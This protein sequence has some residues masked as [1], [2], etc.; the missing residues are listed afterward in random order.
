MIRLYACKENISFVTSM[1]EFHVA[2]RI[3][4][5]CNFDGSLFASSG[6]IIL[7]NFKNVRLFAK[8]INDMIEKEE[9][10]PV[11]A[12]KKMIK[13]GQL[14]AL[15]LIDEIFHYV[16]AL[17]RRD[18]KADVFDELLI[19]L[20]AAHT[21][22]AVD[23]LLL[24]FTAEFPPTPVYRGE[25]DA[26]AWLDGDALD[27]VTGRT[28]SNRAA[29]LEEMILLRL[30]NEN[31]AFK[32]FFLLFNDK[33]LLRN[34]LY[35]PVWS[36]IKS[37]FAGQ[38]V[39]GPNN[40]DLITMLKEPV[41][42]SPD[43]LKGQL[44]YIRTYWKDLL[45]EW[46]LRLL[47]GMDMIS[48][49]EKAAWAP[50][51]AGG[52]SP[53]M[54]PYNYDSL[55]QEYERFSPDREWM[56]KVVLMA[57]T[58]LVWLDQL[59]KKYEREITRLDQ[60]PD[61][62]LDILA[63]RGFTGLWL[64]GLWERS[65]ASKRIKQICGN[66]EAA[67]S[68]YSLYDYDIAQG[69]GGWGALDNLRRRLWQRGIRLASDMVPN[70]T[71]MDSKWINERP[72]LFVQ[73]RD[74]PFPGYTFNGE[75]LSL[76]D[77]VGV[78]LED[79][80]YSKSDCAVVFKRVDHHT[81]DVRYI[82]HGNDGTGMPWNDTAQ[83][84]FLNPEAREAVMQ[85]ILHVAR[86][87]PIIRFD[88]AMVLAKKHIR[89]LWYPEPGH[90]GDIASRAEYALSRD[91]F[92]TRIPNEFW[93]EVV[94]RVAAEV[95]DTLL[96][97]EAFW[98][99]EGYFVRTLGM[100]RVYNSAFMNMLKREDNSKY[101]STIKNTIEFDPQ[102][103]KRFVNFM[104]NP[105]E[106][107]AVAQFGKGDKYF[108]VC[109]L[110]VTMPGLPMFGHGQIE[111]F[112]EKYGM[113]FTKA[114]W[115]E[116]PDGDLIARHERDIFPL[117][118]KRYLFA[119]IENFLFYDVWD[120]GHVNENV[121]AYSNRS[122]TERAVVFY[123][124]V[125][126]QASGWIKQSC[127]YAVKTGSGEHDIRMETHSIG[128]ALGL[129]PDAGNFCIF[130]EQR[131]GLWFI[132]SAADICNNGLYLHLNGFESQV[133]M[134]ISQVT[135][136]ETGKYR[137]LCETLN[138]RGVSDIDTALREIFLKE[139]YQSFTALVT[140]EFLEA[141]RLLCMPAVQLKTQKLTAP[142]VAEVLAAVEPAARVWFETVDT[143][144]EGNYGASVVV[145]RT[146]CGKKIPA[147]KI[148]KLLE[149]RLTGLFKAAAA[150][151]KKAADSFAVTM[152]EGMASRPACAQML[153]G[154]TVLYSIKDVLGDKATAVDTA[155]LIARW[156]L[157]R[158]LQDML[159]NE[160][161]PVTDTY[162]PLRSIL[163]ALPYSDVIKA[164]KTPSEATVSSAAVKAA[165]GTIAQSV[166]YNPAAAVTAGVNEFNNVLWFNE[167]R[168]TDTLWFAVV[169]PAVMNA[170]VSRY[171][172]LETLLALFTAAQKKS[173]YRA[174]VFAELLPAPV[175][176]AK[177]TASK[178]TRAKEPVK[179]GSETKKSASAGS[180]AQ[181][182]SGNHGAG[183]KE[184]GKKKS[185][186]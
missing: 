162:V 125:Y 159:L 151:Q 53:D 165:A 155:A 85:E 54:D 77:R 88:A 43:S 108:G 40:V 99:M 76:S 183:K 119:E 130:R 8:K 74:C 55:M 62:E 56:P 84:D 90:G 15:G 176:K 142:K 166:V 29:T 127:P 96:L 2:K 154:F 134:D 102:V 168:M 48:E 179:T 153:A 178:K 141:V 59:S 146:R 105:D 157:E 180:K 73:T 89:R 75:N 1:N 131:S 94:D 181:K 118:K 147:E 128:E 171:L 101:R 145:D 129:S 126:D 14:N 30:A 17:Y 173:E 32:P 169:V 16:C 164:V 149:K 66:P 86:N 65:N 18:I 111:G 20:D 51:T 6:N 144:I 57:K 52:G 160:N 140:P 35:Q 106:E 3:R 148:W 58:V 172:L 100:H 109:T 67:A 24:A 93:R 137:I 107:T 184:T 9:K 133:M 103:L 4:D 11:S 175:V 19:R 186:K 37:F 163:A 81:G 121:F 46:L 23:E 69:L 60:I 70:H 115:N 135:D 22:D 158:K 78:Y 167:E 92:E 39:F 45:G 50:L 34:S 72:D 21:A 79:H 7:A 42:Y 27:P 123:N 182:E 91:D 177:K 120:N 71:G 161:I 185:K 41:V 170:D 97:A 122:G 26:R 61:E 44:D 5:I 36:E 136:D 25:I 63:R 138:G 110:M 10:D 98:M 143:F 33:F 112:T 152:F 113:E 64:I 31:P 132:R 117:M 47:A 174:D 13:A 28:R 68:A 82:Y 87:F 49:E 80:Y 83:I 114:Y 139:L 12:G 104:N 95:P 150:G 124:N 38:P 116:T 156:G